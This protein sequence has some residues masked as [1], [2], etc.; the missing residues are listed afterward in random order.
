[1]RTSYKT[2]RKSYQKQQFLKLSF[3]PR[4]STIT[5]YSCYWPLHTDRAANTLDKWHFNYRNVS[6]WSY[7]HSYLHNYWTIYADGNKVTYCHSSGIV[8]LNME[9]QH[10]LF[11]SVRDKY[12]S[13]QKSIRIISLTITILAKKNQEQ[14]TKFG[15]KSRM[16][17]I[18][19]IFSLS[20]LSVDNV[21]ST[22]DHALICKTPKAHARLIKKWTLRKTDLVEPPKV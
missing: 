5:R 3:Q 22:W 16:R 21:M 6:T 20:S 7:S 10:C 17:S 13:I 8:Q 15:H 4:W 12:S 14:C 2:R 1:M 18:L 9:N 19:E 11:D